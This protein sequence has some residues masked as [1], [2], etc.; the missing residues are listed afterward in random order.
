M[1]KESAHNIETWVYPLFFAWIVDRES[2]QTIVHGVVRHNHDYFIAQ[3]VERFSHSLAYAD[4]LCSLCF[5]DGPLS[6]ME[7]GDFYFILQHYCFE[8]SSV[9][10]HLH[11][12]CYCFSSCLCQIL[13]DYWSA[14]AMYLA[15]SGPL[16]TQGSRPRDWVLSPALA[17]FTTE[18]RE[19]L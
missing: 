3:I 12:C 15:L 11:T 4:S 14:T 6:S 17:A 2:Q 10:E 5:H 16:P 9:M 13:C 8:K 7:C 18:T 1:G 19:R